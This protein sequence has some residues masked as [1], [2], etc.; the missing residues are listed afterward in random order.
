MPTLPHFAGKKVHHSMK[1]KAVLFKAKKKRNK[2]ISLFFKKQLYGFQKSL[3]RERKKITLLFFEKINKTKQTVI[4]FV[5]FLLIF[6]ITV[7]RFIFF[8]LFFLGRIS[9]T[10]RL[11]RAKKQITID[12]PQAKKKIRRGKPT[13]WYSVKIFFWGF[14]FSSLFVFLPLLSV[15]FLSEL[16]NPQTLSTTYIPKTTKIY[17]RNGKLLYE[18]FATQNRTVVHLGQ[19]PKRLQQATIAI[20]DR[21]FYTHPG[22]DIRGILRAGISNIQHNNLQGGSTITQQLVKSALLNPEPSISRKVKEIMVAFWTERIYSKDKILELYFNYI[23]YGGTAWG[24]QAASEVYFGKR[25]QDL[26]LAES[27]FL[28]GLPR[29]PSI[30]SPYSG[31]GN[32]WKKRQ[33]EV[34]FAMVKKNYITDAQAKKAADKKLSFVGPNVAIKAPHF[35]MF[36]KDLLVKKYGLSE[37]ERGGLQVKTTLDLKT[38]DMVQKTV[39]REVENNAHLSISNGA[40]LVLDPRN[41]DI[42]AMVGSKNYFDM[43]NDGNVNLVTALRQPGSTIKVVTYSLALSSGFTQATLIDDSPL[44]ITPQSGPSYTPVN[45]DGKFH[46]IV[47]LRLAFAN[48]FN[49]TAVRVAQKMGVENIVE[50]GRK[51]GITSW[52]NPQNYGLSITL[53]GADTTMLDLAT[54]YSTVANAG[55]RIDPDPIL[56]VKDSF[57]NTIYQKDPQESQVLD[58]RVAF[59]IGDILSDNRARS[60]EFGTHSPLNIPNHRVSVKTGTT[61]NK[62]DNWTV[63]F[64]PNIVVAT[65]V[66]NNDNSPMSQALA[67]GITGAAPMWNKIIT[68]ILRERPE[69]PILPPSDLVKKPCLGFDMYFLKGTENTSCVISPTPGPSTP[70]TALAQ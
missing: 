41:G 66:G 31:S 70:A 46:G 49:I 39:A 68:T 38:Q 7:F 17:D 13:F 69:G 35:V 23:P 58:P 24:V 11:A 20:E 44:T 32:L 9:K 53:G 43:E 65:W 64:T 16:P 50:Q 8:P 15:V 29:A 5:R 54:V 33:K 51:M 48:S 59:I 40:S 21:D 27:A 47:P 6:S 25:T 36:V 10:K 52:T 22:F 14:V 63:G 26:D 30:Y 61:D 57:G 42:L 56:E 60:I 12:A 19:I 55:K 3:R 1:K 4:L 37:V 67:S 28:A 34:L 18:I 2:N 62:R 45:Y